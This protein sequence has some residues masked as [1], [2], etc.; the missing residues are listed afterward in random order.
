MAKY[1]DY[2]AGIESEIGDAQAASDQRARDAETGRYIPERFKNKDLTDVIQSYEELEKLNS[3]QAQDLGSM[4]KTVDQLLDIQKQQA[5]SPAQEPS[6][7]VSVDDLYDDADGNIR[8]VVREEASNELTTLK[9]ELD[10][11]KLERKLA[12]L[13]GKFPDWQ[14]RVQESDFGSWVQESPYRQRMFQDADSGDFDA[15]EEILGMYYETNRRQEAIESQKQEEAVQQRQLAD[16]TLESGS[17]ARPEMGE[18]YSRN[19]LMEARLSA[20]RGDLKAERWLKAHG[21]SIAKAYEEGRI[22][23]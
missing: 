18:T 19:D 10:K 12:Q 15:A 6:K 21:D 4:R 22:V 20:K 2:A 3:R 7:P 13:E 8:R 5:S 17:P 9:T 14:E 16:A 23:D 1:E 11:L